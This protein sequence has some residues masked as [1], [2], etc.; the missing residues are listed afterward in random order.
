MTSAAFVYHTDLL[1]LWLFANI[2]GMCFILWVSM[3][4]RVENYQKYLDIYIWWCLRIN[5]CLILAS[6]LIYLSWDLYKYFNLTN[7]QFTALILF[8]GVFAVWILFHLVLYYNAIACWYEEHILLFCLL[9]GIL[10]LFWSDN[11]IEFYVMLE[12]INLI[13]IVLISR[14]GYRAAGSRYA[15]MN[16]FAS[17]LILLGIILFYNQVGS[18]SFD[19]IRVHPTTLLQNYGNILASILLILGFIIKLGVVPYYIWLLEVYFNCSNLAFVLLLLLSKPIYFG[20]LIKLLTQIMPL[21]SFHVLSTLLIVIAYLSAILGLLGAIWCS[22]FKNILAFNSLAFSG[23]ILFALTPMSSSTITMIYAYIIIY[24]L[25]LGVSLIAF[26]LLSKNWLNEFINRLPRCY[27]Q[28]AEVLPLMVFGI[29]ACTG[30]PPFLTFMTKLYVISSI[31]A[32]K[33]YATGFILILLHIISI[34]VYLRILIA[35]IRY[36]AKYG[37]FRILE[38]KSLMSLGFIGI[39]ILIFVNFIILLNLSRI[40]SI[41]LFPLF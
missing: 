27:I 6:L 35:I 30:I 41:L 26:S 9:P 3:Y 13:F 20:A 8:L 29:F 4:E 5:I 17:S 34:F 31:F 1:I 28:K 11:F 14:K 22:S 10:Y 37:D 7:V 23:F 19:V 36:F 33:F 15:I 21:T 25:C 12:Y 38:I 24:H 16:M 39:N 2:Y 32:S 18:F 40:C